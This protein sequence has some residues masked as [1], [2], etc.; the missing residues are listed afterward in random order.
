[1]K[2]QFLLIYIF[3]NFTFFSQ[4][5]NSDS[6]VNSQK[7][8]DQQKYNELISK[9]IS[10]KD[11]KQGEISNLGVAV[12]PSSMRFRTNPGNSDTRILTITNDT[13]KKYR[14][15]ITFSDVDMNR[16]GTITGD[17]TTDIGLKN[18][19]VA[20]PNFVEIEPGEKAKINITVNIPNIDAANRAAWCMGIID[21]VQENT[22]I[23]PNENSESLTFG[24]KPSFGFAV[25]FYQ[26]PPSVGV[27][28][29]EILDF[30]FSYNEKNK[31]IHLLVENIGKGIAR[32]KAYVELDE[33]NTGYHETLDL[34]IFNVL[35]S[36]QREFTFTLPGKMPNG[37]YSIMGI[38]DFGSDEEIKAASKEIII[39]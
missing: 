7:K 25:Y 24:V 19:I 35:P 6:S 26:N 1:M 30:S 34:Q 36:R 11:L 37:K 8:N 12:A 15:K 5:I 14:F 18:W 31:Y 13:Y 39:Q 10:I 27:S 17:K 23:A 21:E 3:L 16:E 9:E 20:D 29:V 2:L 4:S 28:E 22:E 33:L 38:L 32:A